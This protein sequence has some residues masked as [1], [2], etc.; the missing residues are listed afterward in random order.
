MAAYKAVKESIDDIRKI[1]F[2]G[3]DIDDNFLMWTIIE[4]VSHS[5][6]AKHNI[7][8]NVQPPMHGDGS[9]HFI[10]AGISSDDV[11]KEFCAIIDDVIIP[12]IDAEAGTDFIY[13]YGDYI[14]GSIPDYLSK[15]EKEFVKTRFYNPNA[16]AWYLVREGKLTELSDKEKKRVCRIVWEV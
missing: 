3:S 10:D 13:G 8:C 15:D 4:N 5:Y 16:L 7:R 11:I 12:K 1:G 14:E 2:V 9:R 6:F